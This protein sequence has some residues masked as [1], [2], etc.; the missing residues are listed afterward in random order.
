[1]NDDIF[2]NEAS[3]LK[4][5]WS[6]EWLDHDDFDEE[7]LKKIKL[8]QKNHGLTADGL[9]GPGTYRRLYLARQ[10]TI[11]DYQP[12]HNKYL[13][14]IVCKG[15]F[16]PIDWP[17]VV[18]WDEGLKINGKYKVVNEKRDVRMFV[19]HWDVCLNSNS[20]A[21]VLNKRG[22]SIH[23]MIDNDG[24]IYQAMDCNN[25]AYHA[26]SSKWNYSSIGVEISN[27]YYPKYQGWYKKHGFDERPLITGETCHGSSMKP[28]MGFY[29]AQID[30]LQALWKACASYYN[31][32]LK[33]P[34]DKAG[35]TLKKVSTSAASSRF[36]GIV[37]H[38]HLT[39]NKID[40]AGLDIEKLL[41]GIR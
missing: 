39:R 36:K 11:S 38:Y 35:N 31:I 19:N 5:G 22:L 20:C 10:A 12:T 33:T 37:S 30:A 7:L 26:G 1:M 15:E 29:P 8:F 24:T 17:K 40:C 9:L 13:D 27:A 14:Y 23:F 32:P 6:P 21:R 34:L 41:Q 4:L 16:V 2:Y 18:L 28:Y 3:A 25:V